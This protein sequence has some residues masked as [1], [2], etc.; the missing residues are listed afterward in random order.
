MCER[1]ESGLWPASHWL[2]WKQTV[3]QFLS[4]RSWEQ[5]ALITLSSGAQLSHGAKQMEHTYQTRAAGCCWVVQDIDIASEHN[6]S[7]RA[8]T[9]SS[10]CSPAF[11]LSFFQ[12]ER[13]SWPHTLSIQDLGLELCASDFS[14]VSPQT[15]LLQL[16]Q[17]THS[18]SSQLGDDRH[19][20]GTG[21]V[22]TS[23]QSQTGEH[24]LLVA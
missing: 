1:E 10:W 20:A 3:M 22:I 4:H 24:T 2:Q 8:S 6:C 9:K 5:T 16:H 17:A 23:L 12:Q 11:L 15:A 7:C 19:K 14:F 13:R 21:S 18:H